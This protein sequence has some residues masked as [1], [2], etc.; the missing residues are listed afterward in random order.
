M[1]FKKTSETIAIS[2]GLAETAPNTFIQEEVALQL[3]ILNNEIFVVLGVDLDVAQPDAVPGT[4]TAVRSSL[5]TTS[6]IG[7]SN[8]S[9]SN[10]VATAFDSI[11]AAGFVDGGVPFSRAADSTP[12]GDI[13][14]IALI[15]TNN[16]F[17]Q[18]LGVANLGAKAVNG[19][20]WGY[21][22]RADSNTYAALV[23]SEVLSA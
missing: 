17:V 8:L 12:T 21:R 1:G 23:Q 13:D 3:D 10:C 22:A 2:F 19:R 6:Q 15:A 5:S 16:F 20:V 7:I 4:D 9:Q 18:L 11:R 14:Y